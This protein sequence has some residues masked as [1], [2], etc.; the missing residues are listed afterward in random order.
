VAISGESA[1]AVDAGVHMLSPLSKGL[2][3]R[4]IIQSSPG[5]IAWL[6]TAETALTNGMNF[7][8]AAGCSGSDA[9]VATCLRSL[10]SARILQL[11][12]TYVAPARSTNIFP[13]VD[14]TIVPMQPEQAR[15]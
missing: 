1:G 14:G 11:Q 15:G 2:F 9:A 5:F 7:A 6:P 4:A 13:F 8:K 3:Q 12:G 10:S